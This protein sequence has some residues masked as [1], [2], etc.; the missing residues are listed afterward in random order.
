MNFLTQCKTFVAKEVC[1]R[2]SLEPF[3]P[4]MLSQLHEFCLSILF[5]LGQILK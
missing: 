3:V 5:I 4:T 1:V 2:G